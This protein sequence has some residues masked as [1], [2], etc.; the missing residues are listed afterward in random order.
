[1]KEKQPLTTRQREV[2]SFLEHH[3]AYHGYP[4]T[5]RDI[6]EAFSFS[7]PNAVAGH[8]APLEAKGWIERDAAVARGI[9]IT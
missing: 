6:A 2:L 3:I 4:P 8:L 9:R 1:M 5:Y 7:G